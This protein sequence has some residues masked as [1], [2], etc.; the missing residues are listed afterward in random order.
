MPSPPLHIHNLSLRPAPETGP[1]R[2]NTE[3][4]GG[5]SV[6]LRGPSGIGKTTLLRAVARLRPV[7]EGEVFLGGRSWRDVSPRGWRRKVA[8]V[9]SKPGFTSGTVWE[10]LKLP[11]RLRIAGNE[12]FPEDRTREL[13]RRLLLPDTLLERET[14]VLSD[15]ERARVGLL[16]ALLLSP[17]AL[18]ADE[19]TG[20][21]DPES[22]EAVTDLLAEE[23][24][25][26]GLSMLLVSHDE[27]LSERLGA[28]VIR[29][30]R[31]VS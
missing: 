3:I 14:R 19:P 20:P 25:G 4:P 31:S 6:V 21:L 23:M 30:E 18:L 11:F 1:V 7:D 26:N 16:R 8:Y 12:A 9:T 27:H 22:R 15:G 28:R 5:S 17:T 13:S 29:V 2:L 24:Q 10:N